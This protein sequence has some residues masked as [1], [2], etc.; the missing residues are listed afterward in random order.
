[1]G[2]GI[3]MDEWKK[4]KSTLRIAG[5]SGFPRSFEILVQNLLGYFSKCFIEI[6]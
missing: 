1:M 6:F 3:S 4:S 5:I 2:F